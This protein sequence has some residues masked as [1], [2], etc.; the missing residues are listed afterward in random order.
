MTAL[1]TDITDTRSEI[2]MTEVVGAI[3]FAGR[4]PSDRPLDKT[5]IATH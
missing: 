1:K 2:L 3:M 5:S 4:Y